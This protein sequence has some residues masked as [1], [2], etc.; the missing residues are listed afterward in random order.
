MRTAVPRWTYINQIASYQYSKCLNWLT[1]MQIWQWISGAIS[2]PCTEGLAVRSCEWTLLQTQQ[3]SSLF[4]DHPKNKICTK[5]C[6]DIFSLSFLFMQVTFPTFP[7]IYIPCSASF[8]SLIPSPSLPSLPSSPSLPVLR[9]RRTGSLP[10]HKKLR[11][12][13][14]GHWWSS[15]SYNLRNRWKVLAKGLK[16]VL[17]CVV[18]TF[19]GEETVCVD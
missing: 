11:W 2:P 13:T 10:P 9:W 1:K 3:C 12:M 7:C 5:L 17:C 19:W 18:C 8:H 16:I 6:F 14:D 15:T 4:A